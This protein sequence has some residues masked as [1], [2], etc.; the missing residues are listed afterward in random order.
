MPE[1]LSARELRNSPSAEP[2]PHVVILGAGASRAAFPHGDAQGTFVPLMSE[3]DRVAGNG[4][5]SLIEEAQPL[6]DNFEERFAYLKE[7]GRYTS[8]SI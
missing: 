5:R 7:S 8:R 2:P 4:W 6:G 1:W 3:L